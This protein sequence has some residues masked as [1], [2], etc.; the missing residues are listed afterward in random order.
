MYKLK[1][2]RPLSTARHL[3]DCGGLIRPGN[4][5][6]FALK[7]KTLCKL[8]VNKLRNS[9][10][11]LGFTIQDPGQNKLRMQSA[12]KTI[13]TT[14]PWVAS[15]R[16]FTVSARWRWYTT[17]AIRCYFWKRYIISEK[18]YHFIEILISTKN[19]L[20]HPLIDYTECTYMGEW[21][22]KCY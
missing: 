15:Y 22:L 6:R 12:E 4:R 3:A 17:I 18:W 10:P 5:G 8:N 21:K 11:T 1:L 7:I 2:I 14:C 13:N 20:V 9:D 19:S 16:S